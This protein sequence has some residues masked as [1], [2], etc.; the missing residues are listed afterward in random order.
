MRAALAFA[1]ARGAFAF[2]FADADRRG[3]RVAGVMP[4]VAGMEARKSLN[5]S[6]PPAEAPMPTTMRL[7]AGVRSSGGSS[8]SWSSAATVGSY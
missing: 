2:A 1:F 4:V 6:R 8:T 3:A 7:S 5:A